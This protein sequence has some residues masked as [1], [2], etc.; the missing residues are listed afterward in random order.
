MATT[1]KRTSGFSEKPP[2]EV[3]EQQEVE[4]MLEAIAQETF[5][6]LSKEEESV[7]EFIPQE[8]V[9]TEDVGPRFVESTPDPIPAPTPVPQL[10]AP[11]KRHP[12]NVPKFSRHK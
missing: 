5:E 11:P 1:R 3:K 12:R 9:P 6:N 8:I 7:P 4:Q 2:E 10:K